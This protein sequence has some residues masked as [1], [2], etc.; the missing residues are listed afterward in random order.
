MDPSAKVRLFYRQDQ[1][2]AVFSGALAIANARRLFAPVARTNAA[3]LIM[4][5]SAVTEVDSA[6]VVELVRL[7]PR[8][9]VSIVSPAG[10]QPRKFFETMHVVDFVPTYDT[11]SDALRSR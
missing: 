2:L 4:D 9:R 11:A 6:A 1:V 10:T 3:H 5:F 7:V 8:R